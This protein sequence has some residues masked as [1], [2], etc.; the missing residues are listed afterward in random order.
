MKNYNND[1]NY[2]PFSKRAENILSRMEN[3]ETNKLIDKYKSYSKPSSQSSKN[4]IS[5]TVS[6][7]TYKK[8]DKY[9]NMLLYFSFA[10]A[11]F[12]FILM[13][14]DMFFR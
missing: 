1:E 9:I 2:Q 7:E 13:G 10:L 4:A 14:F 5:L 6:R 11:I 8:N 3:I 12:L